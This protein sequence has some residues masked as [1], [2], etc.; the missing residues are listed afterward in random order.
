MY[1]LC[2]PSDGLL[3]WLVYLDFLYHSTTKTR[4][5][6]VQHKST[7]RRSQ[8]RTNDENLNCHHYGR[9]PIDWWAKIVHCRATCEV[10]IE[11]IRAPYARFSRAIISRCFAALMTTV[12]S[13]QWNFTSNPRNLSMEKLIGGATFELGR[14]S[15]IFRWH[16]Y[17][18]TVLGVVGRCCEPALS[19]TLNHT[20]VLLFVEHP[21]AGSINCFILVLILVSVLHVASLLTV[22]C[23]D[24]SPDERLSRICT[25]NIEY[26]HMI[27]HR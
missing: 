10:N 8:S 16:N 5:T 7:P 2:D 21:M 6:Q 12:V 19:D 23:I 15:I 25:Y 18:T 14:I 27:H 1:A 22:T 9:M 13:S 26:T 24:P 20:P 17:E 11:R 4:N 3:F